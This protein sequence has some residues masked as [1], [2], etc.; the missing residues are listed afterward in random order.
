MRT[1][2]PVTPYPGSALYYH[3][4][5]KGLLK[6]C[7]DFYEHKHTNSDL[8]SVN[9]TEMSND[10]FHQCLLEANKRL[11]KNYFDNKKT[12]TINEADNLYTGKSTGFRGF[13]QQ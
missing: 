10:D 1:I 3:A 12:E 9:F 11:I 2:R 5:E 4:I 7:E 13:R 8:L 6:D